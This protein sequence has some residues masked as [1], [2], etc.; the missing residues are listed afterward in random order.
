MKI[1]WLAASMAGKNLHYYTFMD[2]NLAESVKK[3]EE[4][5]RLKN[6]TISKQV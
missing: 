5:I 2:T 1:Q 4:E 3:E 6:Y